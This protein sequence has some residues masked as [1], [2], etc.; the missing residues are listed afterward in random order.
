[1]AL[2]QMASIDEATI[3]L[4]VRQSYNVCSLI[5]MY[6]SLFDR[7]AE[8]TFLSIIQALLKGSSI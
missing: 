6:M 2:L 4:I 1:M 7:F 3:A 8:C 5:Q